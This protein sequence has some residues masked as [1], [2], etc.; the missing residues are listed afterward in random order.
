MNKTLSTF[1]T[2]AAML[3]MIGCSG[4]NFVVVEDAPRGFAQNQTLGLRTATD[5]GALAPTTKMA[6]L[7]V[8]D[9]VV[10]KSGKAPA[11]V[12]ET[13]SYV[14]CAAADHHQAIADKSTSTGFV[15]GLAAPVIQAGAMVGS[16]ALLAD[17]IRDS[18]SRTT[19]NN[20]T[21]S[22]AKNKNS[23]ENTNTNVNGNNA[24]GGAGG[25]GQGGNGGGGGNGG[26]GGNGGNGG[27][28]NGGTPPG[29]GNNN[30]HG[31]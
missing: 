27:V 13:I 18:G 15:A 25:N 12:Y 20:N 17:G 19:N 3:A 9:K 10:A 28:G 30:P 22:T 29:C 11:P 8:C 14:N 23:N 1:V 5:L 4:Q 26:S 2:G 16:A 24:N 7:E 6:W 21:S 31:C